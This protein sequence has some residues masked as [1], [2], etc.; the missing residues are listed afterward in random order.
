MSGKSDTE[1]SYIGQEFDFDC[2]CREYIFPRVFVHFLLADC[3]FWRKIGKAKK[4][5]NQKRQKALR[6]VAISRTLDHKCSST[7]EGIKVKV[8]G[9]I[10]FGIRIISNGGWWRSHDR[11]EAVHEPVIAA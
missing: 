5:K 9:S 4:K 1:N 7:L 3:R 11:N 10:D 8:E 6:V 2:S